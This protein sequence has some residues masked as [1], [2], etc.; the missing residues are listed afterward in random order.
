MPESSCI[1]G[2]LTWSVLRVSRYVTSV[3]ATKVCQKSLDEEDCESDVEVV[4]KLDALE[5]I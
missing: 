5:P 4:E 3:L 2:R 1:K